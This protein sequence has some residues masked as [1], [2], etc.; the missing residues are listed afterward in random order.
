MFNIQA[1]RDQEAAAAAKEKGVSSDFVNAQD[2]SDMSIKFPNSVYRLTTN[3]MLKSLIKRWQR[4]IT[5]SSQPLT[6]C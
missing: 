5:K 6:E 3:K 1:R 4:T 2:R